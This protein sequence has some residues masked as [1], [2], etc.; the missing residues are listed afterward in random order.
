M[1][2]RERSVNISVRRKKKREENCN[3]FSRSSSF[4]QEI[5]IIRAQRRDRSFG[6]EMK[7][8]NFHWAREL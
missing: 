7:R 5:I 8:E 2:R 1:E 6:G 4:A 3:S